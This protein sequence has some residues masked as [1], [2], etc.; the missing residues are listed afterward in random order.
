MNPLDEEAVGQ[1]V[2][3][4]GGLA[5]ND[6]PIQAINNPDVV[7]AAPVPIPPLAVPV[8]RNTRRG[9]AA[10][11]ERER[12]FSASTLN[13]INQST[14]AYGAVGV[15]AILS[16]A[17]PNTT[18]AALTRLRVAY[19]REFHEG[20][21]VCR[22]PGLV[23]LWEMLQRRVVQLGHP[24]NY[25]SAAEVPGSVGRVLV[26]DEMKDRIFVLSSYARSLR[27]DTSA[28]MAYDALQQANVPDDADP[29]D[30][31]GQYVDC[32]ICYTTMHVNLTAITCIAQ[33]SFIDNVNG[34]QQ[35]QHAT[36]RSCLNRYLLENRRSDDWAVLSCPDPACE[37]TFTRSVLMHNLSAVRR[38]Q[39]SDEV[40]RAWRANLAQELYTCWNCDTDYTFDGNGVRPHLNCPNCRSESCRR[41]RQQWPH[42]EQN[43]CSADLA[44][45]QERARVSQLSDDELLLRNTSKPC[46]YCS[47]P[48]TRSTACSHM[49]HPACRHSTSF[50]CGADSRHCGPYNCHNRRLV[51]LYNHD[52]FALW[53]RLG[54]V[55]GDH[56]A[57]LV[58]YFRA[59]PEQLPPAVTGRRQ[60]HTIEDNGADRRYFWHAADFEGNNGGAVAPVVQGR[61]IAPEVGITLRVQRE[62]PDGERIGDTMYIVTTMCR[63]YTMCTITM[64][65]LSN[66]HLY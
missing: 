12:T 46:A 55:F 47:V 15:D 26:D 5:Y 56:M 10:Q 66:C 32:C 63:V 6:G 9:T 25:A 50:C 11:Y 33:R 4:A 7:V 42:T 41:C 27:Q 45:Q 51:P 65:Q 53:R 38:Q 37:S 54:G 52:S 3:V 64:Y 23:N 17:F 18:R 44:A 35:P 21:P 1:L 58:E 29:D 14:A 62:S 2:F 48:I 24:A 36:C 8:L 57:P 39:T 40:A 61:L 34:S 59:H 43:P 31:T 19:C 28:E 30:G 60:L 20:A 16:L 13:T 22:R 49:Y